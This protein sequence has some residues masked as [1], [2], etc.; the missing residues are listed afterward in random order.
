MNE[1]VPAPFQGLYNAAAPKPVVS[2]IQSPQTPVATPQPISGVPQSTQTPIAMPDGSQ[3]DPSVVALMHGLKQ[4]ESPNGDYNAIGDQGT[5]AGIGQWSNQVN[6]KV[7]PLQ[8]GQ[9][10]TNFQ[11]DAKQFGLNSTD[12][13]PENQN[14]VMYAVLSKDKADGLTPEQALSKWNSGDPNKYLSSSASGTGQVGAYDVASYV[15]KGMAAAQ[16]YAQQNQQSPQAPAQTSQG[17]PQD[18]GFGANVMS[19]NLVGAAKNVFNGAFPIVSD[20]ANDFNG[21]SSKTKLQQLGDLGMSALWFLPFGDIAEGATGVARSAMG[22]GEGAEAT[23][24]LTAEALPTAENVAKVA[25]TASKANTAKLIGNV[26]TGLGAGYVGDVSNN[27]SQGQTGAGVL[28]PGLGTAL[29]GVIPVGLTGASSVYNKFA[30]QQSIVDKIQ[31]AYEDAAGSTKSGIK[32]MTKTASKGL[33]SN[34]EFL[35]NAGIL[36]ETSEING[37]RVFTTGS[38]SA[39]QQTLQGRINDLTALRDQAISKAGMETP[40]YLEDMRT[41]ALQEAEDEFSGTARD[42]VVNHINSEFDAYKSQYGDGQGNISL[43]DA[44]KIKMD[45]QG[46]TNYDATRPTV[47]TRANSM[48]ATVAKTSVED[49]ADKAGLKGVREINK[50]IQQ[51]LDAKKFLDRINGQTIKGGRIGKYVAEGVGA[52]VGSAVGSAV[53]GAF[54]NSSIGAGVGTLAGAG[55]GA[56]FSKFLQKFTSGGTISAAAIGRMAQE[57]PEVVQQ[58]LQYLSKHG[59]SV[60]PMLNPIKETGSSIAQNVLNKTPGSKIRDLFDHKAASEHYTP[61]EIEDFLK[62][63][64][65]PDNEEK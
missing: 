49:G 46:K 30:G 33:D 20:L 61:E 65:N 45:L 37:R 32:G 16:Q 17:A 44:N 53:G 31:S 60:A 57:D 38:D 54:G 13:S 64:E 48:M 40:M 19:G 63:Q 28:K 14:K 21:S 18:P 47:L 42:T 58:F 26:A 25:S 56:L 52:T 24:G 35:A 6:G 7:Q 51:H 41:K 15:Q 29:G 39:S 3:V 2:P 8:P 22:L 12:F 36:P 55:A 34:P 9:I 62:S 4:N 27:L 59:E 10:P 50:I 23:A 11:N 43:T 5:A 1:T